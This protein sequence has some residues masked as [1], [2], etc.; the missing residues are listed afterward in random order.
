MTNDL[1]F[2]IRR[3]INGNSVLRVSCGRKGFSIQTNGNLPM[4]HS[5][6]V[7]GATTGEVRAYVESY[8]TARQ[9]AIVI[10]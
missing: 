7:C 3:D 2:T 1:K 6:G 4:T 8:G 10:G 5:Q 9:K